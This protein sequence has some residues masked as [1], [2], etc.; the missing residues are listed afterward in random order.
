MQR[1][2]DISERQKR[3]LK[4]VFRL[5]EARGITRKSI[6]HDTGIS[7]DTLG[8]WARGEAAMS[9]TG[10]FQLVGV[11][12]DDLLSMLLPEGR[13]IVQLPD[14]LDHDALSDLA[15]DYLTTKAAAHKADSPAGVDIAPCE[16]AILD[17]K[18][19]QL[20]KAAA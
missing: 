14:D 4:D 8:S 12:P 9:I 15:A 17:R 5:A 18:V 20:G 3:A 6:H 11:I 2:V 1:D 13:Q 7:A 16:R 10:L 19:I